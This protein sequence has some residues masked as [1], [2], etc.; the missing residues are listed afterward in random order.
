MLPGAP[1]NRKIQRANQAQVNEMVL[2]VH[3]LNTDM[4]KLIIEPP[5]HIHMLLHFP[6]DSSTVPVFPPEQE[7]HNSW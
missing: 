4:Q 1:W 2:P 6:N 3:V 7:M 5:S